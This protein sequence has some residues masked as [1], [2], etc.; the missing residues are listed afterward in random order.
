M[1]REAVLPKSVLPL[2]KIEG[3]VVISGGWSGQ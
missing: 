1:L 3:L 2:H